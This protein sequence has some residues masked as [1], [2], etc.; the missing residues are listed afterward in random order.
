MDRAEKRRREREEQKL[1][2]QWKAKDRVN[3]EWYKSIKVSRRIFIGKLIEREAINND[4]TVAMIMDK[5][6]L[7]SMD[8]N[9]DL[10]II[11]MKK[12]IKEYNDYILEYKEYLDK[13][14]NG[15]MDMIESTI[16]RDEIKLKMRRKII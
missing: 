9:T 7:A 1:K 4:N 3:M 12:I 13:Y 2:D 16:T 5:F 6:I 10:S 15:G 8:D 14:G 11:L